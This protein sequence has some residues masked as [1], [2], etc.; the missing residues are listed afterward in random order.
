MLLSQSDF[1][2]VHVPLTPLTHHLISISEFAIMKETAI[3]INTARGP[4]V[5]EAALAE[6]LRSGQIRAA[7]LDVYEQEPEVKKELLTLDNAVLCP[8]W[9]VQPSKPASAWG[10]L[11]PK[12]SLLLCTAR[13]RLNA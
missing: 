2:S 8:H 5:D 11:R 4:V 10:L 12:I 13:Y 9:E 3:L 7:G 6:A 1:V